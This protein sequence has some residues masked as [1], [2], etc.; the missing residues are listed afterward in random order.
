MAPHNKLEALQHANNFVS[1]KSIA[2]G[3]HKKWSLVNVV[4]VAVDQQVPTPTHGT[5]Q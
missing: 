1:L 3:N 4:G 2:D 5:G